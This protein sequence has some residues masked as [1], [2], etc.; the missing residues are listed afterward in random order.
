MANHASAVKRNRQ[1]IRRAARNRAARSSLRT[2][3]KAARSAIGA[4]D[5]GTA[6]ERALAAESALAAAA[7]KGIIKA[8]T[9]SRTTSRLMKAAAK[10]G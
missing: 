4:G 8:N 5:K 10:L 6:E 1:R 9:A 2:A 3:I 7:R